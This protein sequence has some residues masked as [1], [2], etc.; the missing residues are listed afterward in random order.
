MWTIEDRTRRFQPRGSGSLVRMG[1]S[2]IVLW[3]YLHGDPN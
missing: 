1:V 2:V 3:G